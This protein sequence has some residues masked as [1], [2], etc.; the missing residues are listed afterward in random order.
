MINTTRRSINIEA[1]ACN[2]GTDTHWKQGY[3]T[4]VMLL[5][6]YT[7]KIPPHGFKEPFYLFKLAGNSLYGANGQW[8]G[9]RAVIPSGCS[10]RE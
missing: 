9:T 10:D 4:S 2:G 5:K 8:L 1:C 7:F 3:G 6:K